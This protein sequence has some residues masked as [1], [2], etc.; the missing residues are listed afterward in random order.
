[1]TIIESSCSHRS[2]AIRNTSISFTY[3]FLLLLLF[4]AAPHCFD[5]IP[6]LAY[7]IKHRLQELTT[8]HDH[9][10]KNLTG[11]RREKRSFTNDYGKG[12]PLTLYL[13]IDQSG[14][15]KQK[16]FDMAVLFMK[17]LINR[18]SNSKIPVCDLTYC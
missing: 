1:M 14:S 16:D 7:K 3:V 2:L 9:E 13:V 18:V 8:V 10:D 15:I 11:S 4:F 5:T 12:N 6:V 17:E